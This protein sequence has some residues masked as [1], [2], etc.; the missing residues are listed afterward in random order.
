MCVKALTTE[1]KNKMY[2]NVK[3]EYCDKNYGLS[4]QYSAM[5]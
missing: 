3:N 1:E 2:I 4:G 5:W